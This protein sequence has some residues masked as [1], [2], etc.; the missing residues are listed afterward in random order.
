MVDAKFRTALINQNIWDFEC[1]IR[2]VDGELRWI[3][4]R[5]HIYHNAQGEAVRMLGLIADISE[6]Q[7]AL[8][9][10]NIVEETLRGS[11]ER[12]RI[13]TEVSP[14]AI[15][16][17][18]SHSGITYCNQYWFDYSGL[19]MEQ[20]TGY[21]WIDIIHPEDRDRVFKTSMQAT[22]QQLENLVG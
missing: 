22:V 12:Y 2:R 10:R 13:L 16:M 4:A 21:G 17:G 11:E 9:D 8:R 19:I 7:A 3:W 20:T 1:R 15:W 14:Q 6:Q 5:G 18:D